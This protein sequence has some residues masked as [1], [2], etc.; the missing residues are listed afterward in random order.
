MNK[1]NLKKAIYPGSFDPIHKGHIN[2]IK[3]AVKLF[4][5]VY[6]IVSINPDKN[7]L[8][9]I[10][11]RFLNTK[12]KL[13]KFENVEVLLNED[14]FIANIA[15][16][17]DCNYLIRSARNIKDYSYEIELA[18]GN[19]FLNSNLETILIMPD[20]ENINYSSTLLRHGKKL[21]KNNV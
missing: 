17:H 21:N 6:V 18:A 15:K 11:T 12:K 7:N 3:K 5:Y 16:K 19:K 4:D 1:N 10:K 9:G 14:D 8:T 13:S 20:Y 2:I